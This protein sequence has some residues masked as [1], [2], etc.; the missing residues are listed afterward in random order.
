M[1][2]DPGIAVSDCLFYL[3]QPPPAGPRRSAC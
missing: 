2:I 1:T 3:A